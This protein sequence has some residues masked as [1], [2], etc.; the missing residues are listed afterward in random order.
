M[1][2]AILLILIGLTSC[3]KNIILDCPINR[4]HEEY[5]ISD[6]TD[7]KVKSS[8]EVKDSTLKDSTLKVPITFDVTVKNWE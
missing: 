8:I 2:K 5:E 4:L 1:K 3:S 7:I 6:S